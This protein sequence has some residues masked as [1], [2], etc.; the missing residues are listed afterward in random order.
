M[1]SLKIVKGFLW[2]III[3]GGLLL[4][5]YNLFVTARSE[6]VPTQSG[7][8]ATADSNSLNI[9]VRQTGNRLQA[10]S[11]SSAFDWQ[12]VGPKT[13]Q[14]C[15]TAVFAAAGVADVNYG[16]FVILGDRDYNSFYCFRAL[17][18]AGEYSY[19][20]YFVQPND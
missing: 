13:L 15:D 8:T 16:N 18:S 2:F 19:Q 14:N 12:Y 9:I 4:A 3:S 17:D 11:S 7:A 20:H 10:T 1:Q 5:G 6:P